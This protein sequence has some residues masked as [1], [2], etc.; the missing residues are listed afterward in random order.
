MP[1]S[2]W[3]KKT[4]SNRNFFFTKYKK[5]NLHFGKQNGN[6]HQ[7]VFQSVILFSQKQRLPP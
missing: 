1:I 5:G 4:F 6:N 7:I 3:P 2:K